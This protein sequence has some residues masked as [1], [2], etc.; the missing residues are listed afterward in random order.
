[1]KEI[2][3]SILIVFG[4][5]MVSCNKDPG[6][7]PIEYE[8][9]LYDFNNDDLSGWGGPANAS[10]IDG[11]LHLSSHYGY[12]YHTIAYDSSPHFTNGSIEVDIYP[13]NSKYYFETKGAVESNG[14]LGWGIIVVF[15]DDSLFVRQRD[16][17]SD[18]SHFVNFMYT[19]YSWYKM[20]F[21][22]NSELGDK[23]KYK[24]W[25][26]SLSTA[27]SEVYL[28]EFDYRARYG[29]LIGINQLSLGLGQSNQSSI[30]E[31]IFDNIKFS[32]N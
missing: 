29:R 18:S 22:F 6:I 21:T 28:G 23:G 2:T 9:Y 14:I 15:R 30:I 26:T 19:P 13:Q 4:L 20:R 1:M 24:F 7:E 25:I 12:K 3:I 27:N 17:N 32:V 16:N 31:C 10:I 5:L 8:T 11:E